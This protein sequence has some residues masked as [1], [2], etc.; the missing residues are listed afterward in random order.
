[1]F[2]YKFIFFSLFLFLYK[3]LSFANEFSIRKNFNKI[4]NGFYKSEIYK[5]NYINKSWSIGFES[6]PY[7]MVNNEGAFK[8]ILVFEHKN[9]IGTLWPNIGEISVERGVRK[10]HIWKK[11]SQDEFHLIK[12]SHLS[13]KNS[14]DIDDES[15]IEGYKTYFDKDTLKIGTMSWITDFYTCEEI[16][17]SNFARKK[18]IDIFVNQDEYVKKDFAYRETNPNSFGNKI[19]LLP[20]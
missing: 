6:H 17:S 1:M 4:L 13:D 5:C 19:E 9:I 16:V 2:R 7:G 18:L 10:Y 11:N 15:F 12:S 3:S 8:N 14:S 20:N